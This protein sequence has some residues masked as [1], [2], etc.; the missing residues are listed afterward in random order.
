[1]TR[2]SKTVAE[3]VA[4]EVTQPLYNAK[5]E[6]K[7]ALIKVAK[8]MIWSR[9][10]TTVKNTFKKFPAYIE[11]NSGFY[12]RGVG[13]SKYEIYVSVKEPVP[14]TDDYVE[15]TNDEAKLIRKVYD[16]YKAFD[17]KIEDEERKIKNAIIV[18]GTVKRLQENLPQLIP[19]IEKHLVTNT[20]IAIN[21]SDVKKS[22]ITLTKDLPK[23]ATA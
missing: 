8:K 6:A 10:P 12:M 14:S 16:E 13:I 2:I 20:A 18:F 17:K 22:I 9:V 5:A 11:T 15:L 1:M 4:K 3:Q 7:D 23:A 19:F 21:V